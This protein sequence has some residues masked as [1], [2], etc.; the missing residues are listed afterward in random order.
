MTE[1]PA[2][3]R[4]A[5]LP[6]AVLVVSLGAACIL[7]IFLYSQWCAGWERQ[8]DFSALWNT[9][10]AIFDHIATT[11]R[12]PRDWESLAPSLSHVRSDVA[13]ARSR[14]DVNFNIDFN[15]DDEPDRWYVRVKSGSIPNEER[16]AKKRLADSVSVHP[17]LKWTE[18]K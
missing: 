17:T 4:R 14:V 3:K 1:K 10:D 7:G 11:R 18:T 8:R 5:W 13:F 16:E 15:R 9:T 6:G 2:A 12:W